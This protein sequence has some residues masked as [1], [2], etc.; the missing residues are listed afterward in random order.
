M[1]VMIDCF[2]GNLLQLSALLPTSPTTS[3]PSAQKNQST[4][5]VWNKKE[6]TTTNEYWISLFE[7]FIAKSLNMS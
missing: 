3:L 7:W 5:D 2:S 1:Y 6:I 4:V